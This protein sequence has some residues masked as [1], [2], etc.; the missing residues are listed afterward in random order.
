M[1]MSVPLTDNCVAHAIQLPGRSQWDWIPDAHVVSLLP[2]FP[3][4]SPHDHPL[5]S[6][7]LISYLHE[8]PCPRLCFS[9]QPR[10]RKAPYF[11]KALARHLCS[12]GSCVLVSPIIIPRIPLS[13]SHIPH[14]P[15]SFLFLL[16]CLYFSFIHIHTNTLQLLAFL[17]RATVFVTR[18]DYSNVAISRT[19]IISLIIA[20]IINWLTG[21]RLS[22]FNCAK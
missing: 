1:P 4:P 6:L 3:F 18:A 19:N 15:F 20:I 13:A 8:H 11:C 7:P 21:V 12:V 2:Y 5:E 9:W 22:T 16:V 17:L 10:L 14:W